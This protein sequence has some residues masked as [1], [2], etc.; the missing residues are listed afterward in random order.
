MTNPIVWF[1]EFRRQV[2]FVNMHNPSE[3]II[4]NFEDI[5]DRIQYVSARSTNERRIARNF[6]T[7]RTHFHEATHIHAFHYEDGCLSRDDEDMKRFVKSVRGQTA[8]ESRSRAKTNVGTWSDIDQIHYGVTDF[9]VQ[10]LRFKFFLYLLSRE[11][12]KS[13][14]PTDRVEH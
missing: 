5:F 9:F 11:R 8:R 4:A 6:T 14:N 2:D 12:E 1:E 10:D 3:F 13:T 7:L